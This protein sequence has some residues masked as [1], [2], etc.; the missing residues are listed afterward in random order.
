MRCI[1]EAGLEEVAIL[2]LMLKLNA[3]CWANTQLQNNV[4][5]FKLYL[6]EGRISFDIQFK[7]STVLS[8]RCTLLLILKYLSENVEIPKSKA[9]S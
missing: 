2:A 1:N 5:K 6:K 3:P 8:Y 4:F 9:N 7:V